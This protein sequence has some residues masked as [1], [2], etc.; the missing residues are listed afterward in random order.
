MLRPTSWSHGHTLTIGRVLRTQLRSLV[1]L[2]L[3]IC[4]S[5]ARRR[6]DQPLLTALAELQGLEELHLDRVRMAP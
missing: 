4:L 1:R 5:N 6:S 2:R 3:P